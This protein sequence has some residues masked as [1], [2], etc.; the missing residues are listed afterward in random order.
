LEPDG[1]GTFID[2]LD[3]WL[4]SCPVT[5]RQSVAVQEAWRCWRWWDKGALADRFPAGIPL[6]LARAIE[7]LDAGH[8][9]GT[10]LRMRREMDK[11]KKHDIEF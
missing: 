4:T 2:P 11:G 1:D 7:D 8:N 6:M 5:L 10:A 9:S 3:S